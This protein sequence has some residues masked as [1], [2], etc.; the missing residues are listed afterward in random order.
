MRSGR[1]TA[2]A[3]AVVALVAAGPVGAGPAQ[4]AAVGEIRSA[5]A[6]P[7]VPGGFVVGLKPDRSVTAS[8]VDAAASALAARYGGTVGHVY[9]HALRGFSASMTEA[10]AKRLAADPAVEFVQRDVVY[11][12]DATQPNP[13]SWGLDRIDQRDRPL[14][15][16]YS[17]PNTAGNVHAY[18]I[19]TGIRF[20]HID[21]GGR[22]SSGFD[23]VDGG[24]ADDCHGHGTH[25][26]G[27]V[28]GSAYGVAK[29]VALVAVRVLDCGGSGTTAGVIAGVDWVTGNAVRPAVA[30]MSLGGGPDAA[31]DSAVR[32]SINSGVT[33]AIAAGNSNANACSF[34]PARTAE[35]ITVGATTINDARA[36]FSNFGTCLDIFAPGQ[37]ITS[38]W[39]TSDTATNTISGTS[40]ASPHVA[41][42]AAL[43]LSANPGAGAAAVRD[44]LVNA[45][46]V[47]KV[48][49]PGTGSPN[50]LLFVDGGS[51]PPPPG[52]TIALR[53]R[54]NGLY[55]CAENAGALPLIAN[56]G[57]IGPWE[58]FDVIDTGDGFV[59]LRAHAN[60]RL[61]TAENAGASPLIAN[62]DAIGLWE[63]FQIIANGD[64][65]VSLR[66]AVNGRYVAAENAGAA[67]LIANR[68]A[69]GLWEEFDRIPA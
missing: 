47:N 53:A 3:I 14:N 60:G 59:S 54:V 11:T 15:A 46:S 63:K 18:I 6:A 51:P 1:G 24:S 49:S 25:V 39:V 48:S 34:S 19:D 67:S 21:F 16:S 26:A 56:R 40:M 7:V 4:A 66:A 8:G 17:Y 55:V 23:A 50:R 45:A 57:A 20:T 12:I 36:S 41:G 5:G 10:D 28:G 30:N 52:T 29:G 31:L 35:A 37:D 33:Y 69:I 2:A 44:S 42:A 27:T 43:V 65:S 22:A 32:N 9:R 62:R 61:V 38:A 68:D 13:P 58:Q 64:G